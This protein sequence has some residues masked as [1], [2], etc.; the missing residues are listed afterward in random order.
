MQGRVKTTFRTC[1][2]TLRVNGRHREAAGC[3]AAVDLI[4]AALADTRVVVVNGARQVG[5]S[6][7]AEVVLRARADGVARFLDDPATRAAV[8]RDCC[9]SLFGNDVNLVLW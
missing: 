3:H 8:S 7:L 1:L 2:L 6:T 5:K 4:T 9:R